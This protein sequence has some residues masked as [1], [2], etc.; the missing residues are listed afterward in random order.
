MLLINDLMDVSRMRSGACCCAWRHSLSTALVST[1][2]QR[3]AEMGGDRHRVILD[4]PVTPL[5]VAADAVRLEQ[6]LD[7]LLS[8]AVKSTRRGA[9][10]L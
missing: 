6:I 9:R 4:L 1:V 2:A 10:L 5:K 3:Y 7:N 8:N